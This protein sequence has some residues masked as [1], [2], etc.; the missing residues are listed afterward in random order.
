LEDHIINLIDVKVIERSDRLFI[1]DKQN[2]LKILSKQLSSNKYLIIVKINSEDIQTKLRFIADSESENKNTGQRNLFDAMQQK[3]LDNQKKELDTMTPAELKLLAKQKAIDAALKVRDDRLAKIAEEESK[4]SNDV[5]DP[6]KILEEYRKFQALAGSGPGL[7]LEE[8]IEDAK[9]VDVSVNYVNIQ[10][11]LSIP[12]HQEWKKVLRY[13]VIVTDDVGRQYHPIY[14]GYVGNPMS[15]VQISGTVK[16][17]TNNV[18]QTFSGTTDNSGEYLGTFLIPDQSTTRG[19]YVI[20]VYAVKTF[21]DDSTA[22]SS[23]DGIFYVF[24]LSGSSN[25]SPI[26]EAGVD[27]S[28]PEHDGG[29]PTF[30]II[31]L[32]GSGSFDP[33]GDSITYSWTQTGFGGLPAVTLSD[34]TAESLTFEAPD[35]A[36]TVDLIFDLI[37]TNSQGLASTDSV[38]IEITFVD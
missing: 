37:V 38:T 9:K 26:A 33:N 20:S 30:T 34:D 17:P 27:Q 14:K 6:K 31:T 36:A 19:E 24:P 32:D 25:A 7:L 8:D 23:N 2:G 29:I 15:D 18:L 28:V 3:M 10:T 22:T 11:F 35:I 4:I 16:N 5:L 1:F 21:K 13:T 12:H